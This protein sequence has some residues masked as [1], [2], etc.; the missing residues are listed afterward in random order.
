MIETWI[1]NSL[2]PIQDNS[3]QLKFSFP[4]ATESRCK[5]HLVGV[6]GYDGNDCVWGEIQGSNYFA[7]DYHKLDFEQGQ[8]NCCV[9]FFHTDIVPSCNPK[10]HDPPIDNTATQNNEHFKLYDSKSGSYNLLYL[11][12]T[13]LISSDVITELN[14]LSIGRRNSPGNSCL[15]PVSQVRENELYLR[16]AFC[17]TIMFA[18]VGNEV[19]RSI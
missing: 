14:T 19:I 8:E 6:L 18:A 15:P 11:L 9:H 5:N 17:P 7:T 2:D 10:V 1:L 4:T 13:L 12:V 16:L 3:S